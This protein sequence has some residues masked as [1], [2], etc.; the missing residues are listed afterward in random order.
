MALADR[1]LVE[2][3]VRRGVLPGRAPIDLQRLGGG[4]SCDVLLVTDGERRVVVKRPLGR[5]RVAQRWV[6]SPARALRE[7]EALVVAR[8]IRPSTVPELLDLDPDQLVL[9]LAAAPVGTRTWKADLLAGTV[10]PAVAQSLG[11]ALAEW[12]STTFAEPGRCAR[13]TDAT[14]FV[15]LRIVPFFDR[16]AHVHPQLAGP[17]AAVA[18]RLQDRA[19]CLVHGDFSPKNVLLGP[20][21]LWVIDWETAHVGDPTFDLAFLVAHLAC[22]AVHRPE[23]ASAY[24]Q[25]ADTFVGT[26]LA[27]SVLPIDPAELVSQTACLVLARVDGTSPVEYLDEDQRS[28]ARTVARELLVGGASEPGALWSALGATRPA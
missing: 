27:R 19:S 8:S 18:R 9:T 3:L 7:A 5:L 11:E 1:D 24:Q 16:V 6:A 12:H 17:I 25:C 4:V 28:T 15:E 10:S 20:A 13:L 23:L 2:H 14:N 21:G 22:K 26:Y